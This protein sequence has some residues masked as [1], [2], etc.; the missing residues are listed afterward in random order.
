MDLLVISDIH[1]ESEKLDMLLNKYWNPEKER[2]IFLGDL[3][4]RGPNSLGVIRRVMELKRQ[5]QA[6]TVMGN[7]EDLFLSWLD[8]YENETEL[9]YN[10]G[11]DNTI[12]S[13]FDINATF[14]YSPKKINKWLKKE[15]KEEIQFLRNLPNYYFNDTHIFVHAGVN[16]NL[17]NWTNSSDNDFL[18]VRKPFIYGKNETKKTIVFGHTPTNNLNLDK[19]YDVWISPC[20]TK[21]GIDGGAASG[22]FLH[23][24][25]I[26]EDGT[27]SVHS[28]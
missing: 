1:G 4:D 17:E 9:Y 25:K 26:K 8:D 5:Y 15:F 19:S 21:I 22:G 3:V 11:G 7:H 18:M 14:H 23:G 27:Y 24:L 10:M 2:L 12:N 16:L 6:I 20:K 13:F 28:V